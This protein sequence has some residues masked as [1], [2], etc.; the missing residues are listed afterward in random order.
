MI[1]RRAGSGARL[2]FIL[3]GPHASACVYIYASSSSSSSYNDVEG[4]HT[5]VRYTWGVVAQCHFY[6]TRHC[7]R[8]AADIYAHLGVNMRI[9]ITPRLSTHAHVRDSLARCGPTSSRNILYIYSLLIDC[10]ATSCR[11]GIICENGICRHNA[12][13]ARAHYTLFAYMC[14]M[15]LPPH[16]Q[17]YNGA[18]CDNRFLCALLYYLQMC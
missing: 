18:F 14:C 11:R 10:A 1:M 17:N 9:C 13:S 3:D 16:C 7:P 6:P 8:R 15:S 4:T 12:P 5:H 2:L